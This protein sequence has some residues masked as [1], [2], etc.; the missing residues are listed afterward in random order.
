MTIANLY[1]YPSYLL[2]TETYQKSACG[3][4]LLAV[5]ALGTDYFT[6]RGKMVAVCIIGAATV[7]EV[8]R[9]FFVHSFSKFCENVY[10][11]TKTSIRYRQD[12]IQSGFFTSLK[13]QVKYLLEKGVVID[14]ELRKKLAWLFLSLDKDEEVLILCQGAHTAWIN[15]LA[16]SLLSPVWRTQRQWC[17][18][19]FKRVD[20]TVVT[21]LNHYLY[22]ENNPDDYDPRRLADVILFLQLPVLE[23]PSLCQPFRHKDEDPPVPQ[24][25]D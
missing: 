1:N 6:R 7:L 3:L 15:Q 17:L 8:A 25:L 18:E 2:Y 9:R 4:T 23:Q 12:C 16:L 5:T 21:S 14:A 24:D 19:Y 20:P 13:K 10:T 22:Q 11:Q